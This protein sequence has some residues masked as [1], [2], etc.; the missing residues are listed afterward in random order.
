[1]PTKSN[2]S[3]DSQLL[4]RIVSAIGAVFAVVTLVFFLRAA[5]DRSPQTCVADDGGAPAP[6]E[7]LTCHV[8][9]H[10]DGMGYQMRRVDGGTGI[11]KTISW[12]AP[13]RNRDGTVRDASGVVYGASAL[14]HLAWR[15]DPDSD[16]AEVIAGASV[17]GRPVPGYSGDGGPAVGARLNRPSSV[18][19]GPEGRVY[20]ADTLNDRVRRINHDGTIE[21]VA[22]NG[23]GGL[24]SAG[25]AAVDT[26][27]GKPIALAFDRR[28]NLL[29]AHGNGRAG[30]ILRVDRETGR[31]ETVIG[32][33]A[34]SPGKG[35]GGSARE[36]MLK[37]PVEVTV[38]PETRDVFVAE[39]RPVILH[40]NVG[41]CGLC[42]GLPPK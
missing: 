21:T 39:A 11:I 24:G 29:I 17:A 8:T 7:C 27:I 10:Q 4:L 14:Q 37:R 40:W 5:P 31:V 19:L 13:L 20:V 32:G 3:P 26:A 34:V 15:Q 38:D 22:G 23:D 6:A 25:H 18:A 33:G 28:G 35:D 36:A 30:R 2:D 16:R 41:G 1:M 9:P 42:H 12:D